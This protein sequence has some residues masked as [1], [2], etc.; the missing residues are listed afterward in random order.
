MFAPFA[1]SVTIITDWLSLAYSVAWLLWQHAYLCICPFP[2]PPTTP[3][4]WSQKEV[5][6][7][8]KAREGERK[9]GDWSEYS[10]KDAYQMKTATVM[11]IFQYWPFF[12]QYLNMSNH[13]LLKIN[14]DNFKCKY[15][16]FLIMF[17]LFSIHLSL[18]ITEQPHLLNP[19]LGGRSFHSHS[20]AHW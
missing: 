18:S 1:G 9:L 17:L 5:I 14:N 6:L 16:P 8:I 13:I 11:S 2:P 10:R 12:I 15:H 4:I 20:S 3:A 7:E 19:F